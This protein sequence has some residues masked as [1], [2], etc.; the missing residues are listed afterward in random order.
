MA[1]F[2]GGLGLGL[3][4]MLSILGIAGLFSDATI[5]INAKRLVEACEVSIPRDQHC[6]IIAVREIE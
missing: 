5:G 3:I 2:I 4:A 6:K 1:D